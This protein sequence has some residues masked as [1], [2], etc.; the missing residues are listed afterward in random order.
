MSAPAADAQD[1]Q[2]F[3]VH[4]QS[5]V[6]VTSGVA[7]GR[8]PSGGARDA[9]LMSADYVAVPPVLLVPVCDCTVPVCLLAGNALMIFLSGTYSLVGKPRVVDAESFEIFDELH[10]FA[11]V[12]VEVRVSSHFD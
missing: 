10:A 4:R 6:K 3:M 5:F 1:Q 2:V 11:D 7:Q 8:G 9:V 12:A